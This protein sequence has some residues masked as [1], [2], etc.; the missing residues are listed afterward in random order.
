MMLALLLVLLV[1][2][3]SDDTCDYSHRPENKYQHY[4]QSHSHFPI[5][6]ICHKRQA[7]LD[8]LLW[9]LFQQSHVLLDKSLILAVQDG[10]YPD[11]RDIVT[12][13]GISMIQN[14]ELL[15]VGKSRDFL[16]EKVS[17][18]YKSAITFAMDHFTDS[19]VVIIL[20]DDLLL[21]PDFLD[22]FNLASKLLD[23]DSSVWAVSAWNDN[24]SMAR[25]EASRNILRTDF[26]PGLGWLLKRDIWEHM[27]WPMKHWDWYF[28]SSNFTAGKHCIYPEV[29]RVYHM[30]GN[31]SF[32]ENRLFTKYFKNVVSSQDSAFKWQLEDF[33]VAKQNIYNS[34]I[35]KVLMHGSTHV[36][37]GSQLQGILAKIPGTVFVIWYCINPD[38]RFAT[39]SKPLAKE[40]G[41]WHQLL[42]GSYEGLHEVTYKNGIRVFLI[43][44]Y[45]P[46]NDRLKPHQHSWYHGISHQSIWTHFAPPTATIYSTG[47]KL[48][49]EIM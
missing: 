6:I 7:E 19:P 11:V 32:M 42:R 29:S 33:V 5:L 43:N 23:S 41:I 46:S 36:S 10:K 26:F 4:L 47:Y 44:T 25:K 31:G 22:F 3:T 8:A 45:D 49:D 13:H 16:A 21:S 28:R 1:S 18:H 40:F 30:P 27:N 9:S 24:G 12:K 35:V 14:V 37:H 17:R 34:R 2:A 38:P 20:E 15:Q 39:K 48:V